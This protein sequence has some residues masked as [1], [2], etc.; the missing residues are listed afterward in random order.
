MTNATRAEKIEAAGRAAWV[1]WNACEDPTPPILALGD[2]LNLP[3]DHAPGVVELWEKSGEYG[4]TIKGGDPSWRERVADAIRS[5]ETIP[6]PDAVSMAREAFT[7][8]ALADFDSMK[9]LDKSLEANMDNPDTDA[10]CAAF[11]TQRERRT[12]ATGAHGAYLAAKQAEEVGD[13]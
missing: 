10:L 12:A 9:A 13:A 7:V 8:A 3:D 4:V 2:A 6:T 1:A 5:I 11:E